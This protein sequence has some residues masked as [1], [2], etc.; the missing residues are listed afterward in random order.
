MTND[1]MTNK[2]LIDLSHIIEHGTLTYR[3]LPA[4]I[5]CDYL[6]REESRKIY[7]P[8]TEFQIAK[9]EMVANTG[10]YLDCPFHRYEQGKDLADISLEQFANLPAVLVRADFRKTKAVD[11]DFFEGIDVRGKAVLVNTNWSEHWGTDAYFE[12]NPFLT[13]AA[14]AF[15]VAGGAVLVGIDSHNIDDTNG[16]IRPVHT[17]L[18][19]NDVLIVEHLCNLH[20]L[21]GEGFL[22]SAVPPKFRGV[23]TFPVRA[24]ATL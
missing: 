19:G 11:I 22:F 13:E 1:E 15:L 12:N 16:N 17:V 14:A 4:P 10:T 20:L 9:I 18:L 7:A 5:V 8:G 3:G 23:G 24:F 2:T 6:S 21:P